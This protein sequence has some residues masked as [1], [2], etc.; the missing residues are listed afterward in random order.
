M[1]MCASFSHTIQRPFVP[2][3]L[4]LRLIHTPETFLL[5]NPEPHFLSLF[6]LDS[7][8][9]PA[10]VDKSDYSSIMF[11]FHHGHDEFMALMLTDRLHESNLIV[12]RKERPICTMRLSVT[13]DTSS[14]HELRFDGQLYD[15]NDIWKQQL[16]II[17][18]GLVLESM[19]LFVIA[20]DRLCIGQTTGKY[21]CGASI[22]TEDSNLKAYR[23]HVL[24]LP[25]CV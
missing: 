21:Y 17:M 4:G 13:H 8:E 23:A 3:E 1:L 15:Q 19:C 12:F 2:F 9:P 5:L 6:R 7:S 22:A 18:M 16:K 11:Q 10:F 14:G 20:G 25:L 24:K